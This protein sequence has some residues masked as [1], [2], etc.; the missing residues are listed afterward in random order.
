[1]D[2]AIEA[3]ETI[4]QKKEEEVKKLDDA[5]EI[6][7]GVVLGNA[8]Q[9]GEPIK[10]DEEVENIPGPFDTVAESVEE[11]VVENVPGPFDTV[12]E[13]VEESVT[14]SGP[15]DT[16]PESVEESVTASGPF[17]EEPVNTTEINDNKP[18]EE[19]II[20]NTLSG[21]TDAFSPKPAAQQGGKRKNRKSRKGLRTKRFR[22]GYRR[23]T[24][25]G[26]RNSRRLRK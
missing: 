13:S 24:R 2:A 9:E 23:K 15:F 6:L 12:P 20:E 25:R 5:L 11:E 16:V 14:A 18:E 10:V 8:N 26:R 1:M 4:K 3:V 17:E 22:G 19:G 21:I 7:Q